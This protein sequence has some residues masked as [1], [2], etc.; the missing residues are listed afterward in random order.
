MLTS[1]KKI[2][3]LLLMLS[4]TSFLY[5]NDKIKQMTSIITEVSSIKNSNHINNKQKSLDLQVPKRNNQGK[6]IDLLTKKEKLFQEINSILSELVSKLDTLKKL[7]S[8]LYNKISLEVEKKIQNLQ[9]LVS[10]AVT[11][12]EV[13]KK[14]EEIKSFLNRQIYTVE[15]D[16]ENSKIMKDR[17]SI[18]FTKDIYVK[19]KLEFP[20]KTISIFCLGENHDNKIENFEV[21]NTIMSYT[22]NNENL[23]FILEDTILKNPYYLEKRN[24]KGGVTVYSTAK[25]F[26]GRLWNTRSLFEYHLNNKDITLHNNKF[27][28]Y[29]FRLFHHPYPMNFENL[30]EKDFNE[31]TNLNK[32]YDIINTFFI[33]IGH[34]N[35]NERSEI[36]VRNEVFIKIYDFTI[37]Y[38]HYLFIDNTMTEEQK[39]TM[40]NAGKEILDF[41]LSNNLKEIFPFYEYDDNR[42]DLIFEM[43]RESFTNINSNIIN[44]ETY[45]ESIINFILYGDYSY[46]NNYGSFIDIFTLN[47]ILSNDNNFDKFF[48]YFGKSHIL[49]VMSILQDENIYKN[50]P[51]I[52]IENF[53][54]DIYGF[55][56]GITGSTE[57]LPVPNI[58]TSRTFKIKINDKKNNK[59]N[60]RGSLNKEN[61]QL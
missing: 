5:Y 2:F 34:D 15:K 22:I 19:V 33:E 50:T 9:P 23:G 55:L 3:I 51:N 21:I 40:E 54:D 30:K 46:G 31:R 7:N 6:K 28:F 59:K 16:I 8:L 39:T 44:K 18:N 36:R 53:N 47:K 25:D 60:L 1:E 14:L 38:F 35:K 32:L 10:E 57:V 26:V 29:D 48:L 12:L 37:E 20:N 24:I 49:N 4:I 41:F 58:D 11:N 56:E 45:V 43:F 17:S 27:F 61:I 13:F 52:T 42:F